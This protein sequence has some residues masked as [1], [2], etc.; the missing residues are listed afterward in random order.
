[1]SSDQPPPSEKV[2]RL[3]AAE[4][5][6][7][8]AIRMFFE[9]KNMIAVHTL[10]AAAQGV[11]RDLATPKGLLGI[12]EIGIDFLTKPHL[13]KELRRA[14]RQAQ[15]NFK[16]VD[17]DP[18]PDAEMSFFFGATEF[19]LFDAAYLSHL[20]TGRYTSETAVLTAYMLIKY[21]GAFD[22]RECRNS[23]KN[24]TR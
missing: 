2:T 22:L 23:K 8:V 21:P 16:H 17:H 24:S 6:L 18:N 9:R 20:L 19:Y 13:Q 15:N 4:R 1:M 5:Q 7:N 11:L 10:A 12:F 3:E 14:F